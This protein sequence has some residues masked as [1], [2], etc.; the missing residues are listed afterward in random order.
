MERV[1]D[2]TA[3]IATERGSRGA[4]TVIGETCPHCNFSQ[5]RSLFVSLASPRRFPIQRLTA[6]LNAAAGRA[7]NHHSVSTEELP[8]TRRH[9]FVCPQRRLCG[10]INHCA[11]QCW[12]VIYSLYHYELLSGWRE[13]NAT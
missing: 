9:V 1:T 6:K 3:I 2:R 10:V 13:G 5:V 11:A 8:G 7:L 12:E 4:G